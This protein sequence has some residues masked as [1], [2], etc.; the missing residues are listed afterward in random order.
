MHDTAAVGAWI[1]CH[2]PS[3]QGLWTH[4]EGSELEIIPKPTFTPAFGVA[5][6]F[7]PLTFSGTQDDDYIALTDGD[8]ANATTVLSGSASQALLSIVNSTVMISDGL[9]TPAVLSVCFATMESIGNT[10]DDFITLPQN[11]TQL[12]PPIFSPNRTVTG[13]QQ[14][15]LVLGGHAG[16]EVGWTQEAECVFPDRAA[17]TPTQTEAYSVTSEEQE[18]MLHATA[19]PGQWI[20]CLKSYAN[21]IWTVVTGQTVVVSHHQD[22]G[23]QLELLEA[24]HHLI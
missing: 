22:H 16:D 15:L 19:S 24:S 23:L 8:C 6:S 14:Q 11:L 9:T 2:K 7:I 1:L 12:A 3:T 20:M 4:I 5:G 10:A 17:A 18:F 21:G 13:A